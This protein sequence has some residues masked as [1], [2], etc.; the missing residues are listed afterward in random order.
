MHHK[1]FAASY[2]YFYFFNGEV[3]AIDAAK[4]PE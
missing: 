4:K 3:K 1:F 2:Y